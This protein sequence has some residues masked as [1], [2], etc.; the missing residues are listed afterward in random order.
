MGRRERS[1]TLLSPAPGARRRPVVTIA[2]R[3][4]AARLSA[5]SSNGEGN[6]PYRTAVVNVIE[7]G[8]VQRAGENGS[9]PATPTC[10][11]TAVQDCSSGADNLQR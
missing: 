6:P 11:S 3:E 8:A 1:A 7:T 5:A 10:C 4:A 2:R 9:G